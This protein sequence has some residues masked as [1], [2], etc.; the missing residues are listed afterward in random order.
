MKNFLFTVLFFIRNSFSPSLIRLNYW[1]YDQRNILQKI[2]EAVAASVGVHQ[3]GNL[4]VVAFGNERP[5]RRPHF[6]D[7]N[8][9]VVQVEF[10]HA[11]G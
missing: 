10:N 8:I 9:V 11:Q 7:G 4:G 5:E 2:R 6:T 1:F 3:H